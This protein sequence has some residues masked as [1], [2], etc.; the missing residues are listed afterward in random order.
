MASKKYHVSCET[1][2]IYC[3]YKILETGDYNYLAIEEENIVDSFDREVLSKTWA[4]IY[5][6]YCKLTKDNRALEYYRLK[7][8]LIYLETRK[9]IVSKLFSQIAIRNMPREIFMSY[10]EEIKQWGF[11]YRKKRKVLEDMEDLGRQIKATSNRINI[12]IAKLE[13]FETGDKPVPLEKQ[14][15]GVEYAL[16]K[17]CIDTKKTSV[18]KWVYMFDKIKEIN[19]SRARKVK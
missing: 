13:S 1:L 15:V 16:G 3:F 2:S 9:Q 11:K 10:I 5:E 12:S 14:V 19:K 4:K 18:T 7:G 8:D 17:N 6:E